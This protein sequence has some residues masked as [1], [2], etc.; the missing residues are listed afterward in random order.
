MNK[1]N[2]E[3]GNAIQAKRVKIVNKFKDNC[4]KIQ[5]KISSAKEEVANYSRVEYRSNAYKIKSYWIDYNED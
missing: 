3:V 5:N 4:E 1:W 2:D